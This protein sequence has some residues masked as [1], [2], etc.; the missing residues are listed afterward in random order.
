MKFK[1]LKKRKKVYETFSFLIMDQIL[2]TWKG[3]S[4]KIQYYVHL[5]YIK[6]L[7]FIAR[8]QGP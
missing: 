4:Q 2:G 3:V 5:A 1:N 8:C 7:V 6:M